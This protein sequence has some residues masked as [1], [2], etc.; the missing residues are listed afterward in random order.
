MKSKYIKVL[1]FLFL[2]LTLSACGTNQ[3]SIH[4]S[5]S[6]TYVRQTESEEMAAQQNSEASD[7]SSFQGIDI[8]FEF[9]RQS[10]EASNQIAIWVEDTEGNLIKNIYVTDFTAEGGYQVRE[11]ALNHWVEKADP[12]EMDESEI[13][14]FSGATPTAGTLSYTWDGTDENGQKVEAGQY[15]I[16][17]EGTLYWSS[18]VVYEAL[19]DTGMSTE[20]IEV[21]SVYSESDNTNKDM[22]SN[23]MINYIQ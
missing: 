13:D 14:A 18:N 10:T 7:E 11:D 3:N 9:E 15:K 8:V 20:S 17:I 22:I 16:F 19:I 6:Q 2:V 1:F 4:L 12:A 5:E 21:T 23:V